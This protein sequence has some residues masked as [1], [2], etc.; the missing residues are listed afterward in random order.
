LLLPAGER[1]NG[2]ALIA[3]KLHEA[4]RLRDLLCD[5]RLRFAARAQPKRDVLEDVEMRK[6]RVV[7]KDHAEAA[8]FRRKA[9]YLAPVEKNR[10]RVGSFE[11][12]YHPERRR[13]AAT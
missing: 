9:C 2:A 13:L 4:E 5:F 8:T 11:A 7:L 3:G 1:V 10:A 12:R 6:E